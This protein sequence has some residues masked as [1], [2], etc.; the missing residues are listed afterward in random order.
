M[1]ETTP[2]SQTALLW[3]YLKGFHAVHHI[4][5]GTETGLLERIHAAGDAGAAP[6]ALA[7]ELGLHPPYVD[8]WC[9]TGHHYGV[10]EAADDGRYR[11]APTMDALLV[12]AGDPRH[13]A[14]YFRTTVNFGSDELRAYPEFFRTGAVSRFQEKGHDFSRHVGDTTAG[15]HNVVARKMIAGIPGMKERLERGADVLDV[16]CGVGGLMIK[17]AQAWPNVRCHGVDID[18]HGIEQ[19]KQNIALAALE[20]RVSAELQ[21]GDD[22]GG[23][24]AFDL[25]V[26]FEVLHEIEQSKRPAVIGSVAR[27]LKPGGAL[28][29]LDETY[30]SNLED[31]RDPAFAFAVQTQFNELVWGNVVP[32]REE[33]H[34]LFASA[35]LEEV[36]RQQIGGLFTMLV[37]L[38]PA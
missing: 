21:G 13:L 30:P 9:Q 20:D 10:L 26:M 18:P 12:D 33:Q 34:E 2:E 17:I 38:K 14:P 29:I 4:A 25:A 3:T 27:T 16:G 15:F 28:F 8:V 31:L 5:I 6:E 23:T 36:A 1:T 37:A 7:G 24:A 19:A 32:T 11:L 35:G 22:L